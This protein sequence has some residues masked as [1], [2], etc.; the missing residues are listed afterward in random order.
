MNGRVALSISGNDL[1]AQFIHFDGFGSTRRRHDAIWLYATRISGTDVPTLKRHR[2]RHITSCLPSENTYKLH[3]IR[4]GGGGCVS[5]HPNVLSELSSISI[6]RASSKEGDGRNIDETRNTCFCGAISTDYIY[7]VLIKYQL[8]AC[9]SCARIW[10]ACATTECYHNFHIENVR[11]E[12]TISLPNG[13][14]IHRFAQT[15]ADHFSG[16]VREMG[17]WMECDTTNHCVCSR[18]LCLILEVRCTLRFGWILIIWLYNL[19]YR[20]QS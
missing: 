10:M 7:V 15:Y 5:L 14:I 3:H 17:F 1:R 16:C 20:I 2:T 18:P 19:I 9:I 8:W 12:S 11:R 4:P 13:P 6:R